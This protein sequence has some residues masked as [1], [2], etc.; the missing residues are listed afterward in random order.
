MC[1]S[2]LAAGLFQEQNDRFSRVAA[3]P[4]QTSFFGHIMPQH[5]VAYNS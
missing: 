2:V 3:R 4:T 5:N 1:T